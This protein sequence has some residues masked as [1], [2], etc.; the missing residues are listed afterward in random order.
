MRFLVFLT[1]VL[2]AGSIAGRTNKT[3]FQKIEDLK[4]YWKFEIGDDKKWADPKYDDDSWEEIYVPATWEDE[5]FPGFDGYAWYRKEFTLNQEDT[6]N[7]YYL[8]LGVIDDVDE[9]YINGHFIGFLG[10]YPPDFQT[11]AAIQ[12]QYLVPREYL[13]FNGKNVIAVKVYDEFQEGGIKRGKV[14]LY[15]FISELRPAQNLSGLWMF[16]LGDD[17]DWKE[18][19]LDDG[20]WTEMIVPSI[21]QTQGFKGENGFAWYRKEFTLDKDLGVERLIMLLG[22]IDDLD[23]TYLNGRRIGKTGR[24]RENMERANLNNE[25]QTLR[26]YYIPNGYLNKNGKNILAV[27]VFDGYGHGGIFEG[28]IGII[29]RESYLNWKNTSRRKKD[30]TDFWEWLFGN[31]P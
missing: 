4:G 13:N 14:G 30:S 3:G 15:E 18:P 21:W 8:F 29:S 22:K 2:A 28:P 17:S 24:I 7:N 11:A 23:E 12:R 10:S 9:A 25:W 19:D 1:I 26:A 31:R 6:G 16:K 5:G 27:R 20:G